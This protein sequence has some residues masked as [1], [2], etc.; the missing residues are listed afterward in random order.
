MKKSDAKTILCHRDFLFCRVD[1]CMA[2][3][4]E[5]KEETKLIDNINDIPEGWHDKGR[6]HGIQIL[7]GRWV[8]TDSGDCGLKSKEQGCFYP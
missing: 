1:Q 4:P 2:W 5:Y 8:E 6:R 3:E 7:I